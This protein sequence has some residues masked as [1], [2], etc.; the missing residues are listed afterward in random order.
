MAVAGLWADDRDRA[1]VG[2]DWGQR[3]ERCRG[4]EGTGRQEEGEEEEAEEEGEKDGPQTA[5]DFVFSWEGVTV[6]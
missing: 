3:V 1:V 5:Q 6:G 4:E 2:K